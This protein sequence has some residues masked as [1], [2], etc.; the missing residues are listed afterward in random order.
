[1]ARGT[2]RTGHVTSLFQ[3]AAISFQ[4]NSQKI[5]QRLHPL[6]LNSRRISDVVG[7]SDSVTGQKS[8]GVKSCARQ[9]R[10]MEHLVKKI[11]AIIPPFKLA[12]VREELARIDA[13]DF[14]VTETKEF[15]AGQRLSAC[16]RGT[17]ASVDFRMTVKIEAICAAERASAVKDAVIRGVCGSRT[18]T[19]VV[20]VCDIERAFY[21]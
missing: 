14:T 5:R 16:H 2:V 18:V 21:L 13:G 1:L 15:A 19:S 20:T 4:T 12:D 7:C 10:S 17:E 8:S 6:N 3:Y 9:P 11:E